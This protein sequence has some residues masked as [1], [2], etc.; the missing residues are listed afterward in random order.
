MT[1][2]TFDGQPYI[3]QYSLSKLEILPDFGTEKKAAPTPVRFP[4]IAR[5][6]PFKAACG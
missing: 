1:M 4:R 6:S 3:E 2:T 5:I